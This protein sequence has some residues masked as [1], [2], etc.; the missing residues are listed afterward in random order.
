M[1]LAEKHGTEIRVSEFLISPNGR[2]A[3]SRTPLCQILL[4]LSVVLSSQA[5]LYFQI[6]ERKKWCE[7]LDF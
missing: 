1:Q 7:R 3:V 5:L 2:V 6:K 4:A